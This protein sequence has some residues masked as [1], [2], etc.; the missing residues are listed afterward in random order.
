MTYKHLKWASKDLC[1]LP[2]SEP[3][4]RPFIPFVASTAMS[5]LSTNIFGSAPTAAAAA[6][7]KSLSVSDKTAEVDQPPSDAVSC[8][9]FSPE[10][11]QST[12]LAST[13]WDNLVRI[14]EVQ[15]NGATVPK[16][17]K[18]HQGPALSCCWSTVFVSLFLSISFY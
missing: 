4:S 2:Y 18:S 15:G 13:S 17:E 3:L 11:L 1:L 9:R 8:L 12:F 10:G 14:W 16:A 7:G 5:F 6:T